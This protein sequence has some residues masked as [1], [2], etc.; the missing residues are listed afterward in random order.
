MPRTCTLNRDTNETK[1]QVSINLDGGE[2]APYEHSDFWAALNKA[3]LNGEGEKIDKDHATQKSASQE[4]SVD[5]GIGFLDHMIHA[6]AKHAGWS[7]RIRCKG[8]LHI[9]DHH[10]SED[11]FLALGSAFKNALQGSTGLA[12]FGHAYA[13]LDEALSRAVIDLSNRPYS[14]IELG[15]KREKIGDLSCEM[16]PHCLQSFAQASGTTLHVD[17]IRGDNDHH[18]AESAFKALAVAIRHATTVVKQW[19]GEVRSTKGVLY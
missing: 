4:I 18:R 6:M 8:D 11:T 12:R 17:C 10:T 13:P 16:I 5:T 7:L 9:D 2:L 14:V 3:N 1:I 15:L 19:E